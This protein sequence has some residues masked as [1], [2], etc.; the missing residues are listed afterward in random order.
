MKMRRLE[1]ERLRKGLRRGIG[2]TGNVGE[3]S[4]KM[5]A[6]SCLGRKHRTL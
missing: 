5:N 4:I 6:Q 3:D 1:I 2:E